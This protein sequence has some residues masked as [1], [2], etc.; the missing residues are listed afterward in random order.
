M[1]GFPVSYSENVRLMCGRNGIQNPIEEEDLTVSAVSFLVEGNWVR[2]DGSEMNRAGRL[3]FQDFVRRY[4]GEKAT[5]LKNDW[6][7]ECGSTLHAQVMAE[8]HF[9]E[10]WQDAEEKGRNMLIA[11]KKANCITIHWKPIK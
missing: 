11:F 10:N 5:V 3:F 2:V 4:P 7:S 6:S 9:A 1:K 8:K